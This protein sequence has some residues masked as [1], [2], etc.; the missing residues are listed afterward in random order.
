VRSDIVF[1]DP[2][3][4]VGEL[5]ISDHRSS[6]PT[7]DEFV[8]IAADCHV[9]GLLSNKAGVLH[10]H[11][12]DGA[13]G[14]ELIQRALRDTEL[15]ARVFHPTHVNRRKQLF[16][17]SIELAKRGCHVDITAFPVDDGEDA[18]DAVDAMQRYLAS[19]APREQVTVSSDGGGCLPTYN[20]KGELTHCGI[21]ATGD[22]F[23]TLREL[24]VRGIAVEAALPAFTSN[25]ARH[26]RLRGKGC[27]QPGSDADFIVLS[28]QHHIEHVVAL[29]KPLVQNGKLLARG[30]FEAATT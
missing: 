19:D 14:F 18:Y 23:R 3:I 2:I 21:G 1:V 25:A 28:E 30:Q 10:L 27:L 26:L 12:G 13:R 29:G 15:P 7:F 20:D 6:Q 22:L 5:A 9:A 11:M 24:L 4:G 16:A 8:R 17:D